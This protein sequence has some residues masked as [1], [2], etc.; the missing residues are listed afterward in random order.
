MTEVAIKQQQ[1]VKIQSVSSA[2]TQALVAH[3][4]IAQ[5][6]DTSVTSRRRRLITS[7]QHITCTLERRPNVSDG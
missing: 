6:R 3:L 2:Q 5:S 1:A 7:A 4:D